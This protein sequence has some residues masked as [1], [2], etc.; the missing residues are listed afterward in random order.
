MLLED[1]CDTRQKAPGAC[2]WA[3]AADAIV[4]GEI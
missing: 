1:E 3:Q 2:T 4:V